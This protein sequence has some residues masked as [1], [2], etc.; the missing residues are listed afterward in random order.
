MRAPRVHGGRAQ[1]TVDWAPV[2][3]A[4]G[5]LVHRTCG[6]APLI[7]DHHGGDLLAVPD[8]P[9]VDTTVQDGH[10]VRYAIRPVYDPDRLGDE[11]LGPVSA[12]VSLALAPAGHATVDLSVAAAQRIGPLHRP[13]RDMVGSSHPR[14]FARAAWVSSMASRPSTIH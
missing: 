1:V 4:V 6:G 13:W 14:N 2:D 12:P 10:T 7:V 9:Y 11:P 3:G 5:Y 8:P